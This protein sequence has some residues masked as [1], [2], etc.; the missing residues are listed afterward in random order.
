MINSLGCLAFEPEKRMNVKAILDILTKED[1]MTF[2][3][4]LFLFLFILVYKSIEVK[5]EDSSNIHHKEDLQLPPKLF[6]GKAL[7]N[8]EEEKQNNETRII[9]FNVPPIILDHFKLNMNGI[10]AVIPPATISKRTRTNGVSFKKLSK[11]ITSVED[12]EFLISALL[13]RKLSLLFRA[14]E[15][16]FRSLLFH[17][18]CDNKGPTLTIIKTNQRIFGG[19]N[20]DC[21]SEKYRNTS[22]M[23]EK[24]YA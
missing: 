21:W 17:E 15:H 4:I 23:E 7:Q 10:A 11:I 13:P 3:K 6:E 16:K 8:A 18:K 5:N 14:S 22:R 1:C 20:A 24:A 19:F 9:Y 2:S 12:N